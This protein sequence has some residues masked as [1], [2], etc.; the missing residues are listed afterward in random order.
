MTDETDLA[1]SIAMLLLLSD[2]SNMA[3][4]TH[5]STRATCT[6]STDAVVALNEAT[7]VLLVHLLCNSNPMMIWQI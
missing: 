7:F 5:P 2:M 4:A 6:I 3:S 1:N